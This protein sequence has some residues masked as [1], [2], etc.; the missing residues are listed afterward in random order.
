[1][2]SA[3]STWEVLSLFSEESWSERARVCSGPRLGSCKGLGWGLGG[4]VCRRKG[5]HGFFPTDTEFTE[6]TALQT[7]HL[8]AVRAPGTGLYSKATRLWG[9]M[10]NLPSTTPL[11]SGVAAQ[12][13][14]G[15]V[16]GK[17]PWVQSPAL[18]KPVGTEAHA[19]LS[20]TLNVWRSWDPGREWS[21]TMGLL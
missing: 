19:Q 3:E 2:E 4:C 15:V 14:L 5:S 16:G 11:P 17:G 20:C 21:V 9:D 1:M 6:G 7:R 13:G 18:A 12:Q 10:F 8:D